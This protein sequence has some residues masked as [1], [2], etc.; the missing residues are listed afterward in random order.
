MLAG[1][2]ERWGEVFDPPFN[3]DLDDIAATYLAYGADVVVVQIDHQIVATG[4]LRAEHGNR[5]RIDR[6]SVDRLFRRQ[7]L[8]RQVIEELI[9]RAAWSGFLRSSRD[10]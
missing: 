6:I 3:R 4:I 10:D 8:A 7:G 1:L 5:G 2:E 9:N